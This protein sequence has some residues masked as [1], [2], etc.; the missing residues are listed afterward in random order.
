MAHLQL[1]AEEAVS[2]ATPPPAVGS[3]GGGGGGVVFLWTPGGFSGGNG[4]FLPPFLGCSHGDLRRVTS[5]SG[6]VLL[7]DSSRSGWWKR[8]RS[9]ARA[10]HGHNIQASG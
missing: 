9:T 3:L 1:P 10:Q 4:D 6:R 7:G 2:T 5:G 8:L